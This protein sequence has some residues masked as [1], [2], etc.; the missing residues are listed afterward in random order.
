MY[1][2]HSYAHG[3]SVVTPSEFSEVHRISALTLEHF[4]FP[5]AL[6]PQNPRKVCSGLPDQRSKV[7][8]EAAPLPP[9]KNLMAMGDQSGAIHW[10]MKEPLRQC[11]L[12]FSFPIIFPVCIMCLRL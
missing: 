2:L 4:T 3:Y 9:R 10:P 11:L 7:H 5:V 12:S 8:W 1:T 6:R